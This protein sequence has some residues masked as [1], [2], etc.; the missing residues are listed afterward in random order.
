[1][2]NPTASQPAARTNIVLG[3]LSTVL[4]RWPNDTGREAL[5][6]LVAISHHATYHVNLQFDFSPAGVALKRV[7]FS[8]AAA[9]S[10]HFYLQYRTS[11]GHL[12]LND[13]QGHGGFPQDLPPR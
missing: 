10:L 2:L 7:D 8:R 9:L 13:R 5:L 3:V 11:I 12:P 4:P 6:H 1:M